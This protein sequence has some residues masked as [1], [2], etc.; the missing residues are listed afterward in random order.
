MAYFEFAGLSR[1]WWVDKKQWFVVRNFLTSFNCLMETKMNHSKTLV[2][3]KIG[4]SLARWNIINGGTWNFWTANIPM[5]GTKM[6]TFSSTKS[7]KTEW[8]LME[9]TMG[10]M[11]PVVLGEISEWVWVSKKIFIIWFLTQ[12]RTFRNL[13]QRTKSWGFHWKTPLQGFFSNWDLDAGIR[14][15]SN[16]YKGRLGINGLS[17][18]WCEEQKWT[19]SHQKFLYKLNFFGCDPDGRDEAVVTREY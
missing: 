11:K 3:Q 18:F 12:I 4:D 5:H 13:I 17:R 6:T 15:S 8:L 1:I 19:F 2:S 9:T 10:G 16:Q 7:P 14:T